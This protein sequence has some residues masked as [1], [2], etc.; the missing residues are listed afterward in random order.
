MMQAAK[1]GRPNKVDQEWWARVQGGLE[2]DA[3]LNG[4]SAASSLETR[5]PKAADLSALSPKRKDECSV[6]WN[7]PPICECRCTYY[8]FVVVAFSLGC[9]AML[10]A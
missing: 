3:L 8:L 5:W 10:T 6:R 1:S 7:Q 9:Y 2:S 4:K